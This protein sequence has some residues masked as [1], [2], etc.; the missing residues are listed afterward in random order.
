MTTRNPSN[1][2]ISRR[3]GEYNETMRF[4]E[5]KELIVRI[6]IS[7][8]VDLVFLLIIFFSVSTTFIETS[9]LKLSLPKSTGI[10]ERRSEDITVYLTEDGKIHFGGE[11]VTV[12]VLEKKLH[13][14]IASAEKK[15]VIIKADEKSR[16]GDVVT[17][18]DTARNAGAEG[19]TIATRARSTPQE[20]K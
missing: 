9:G 4:R 20:N 2:E 12:P 10:S 15:F 5:G 6:D 8:L 1:G 7:P 17:V 18:M 14:A 11:Q 13:E 16:H 3:E 19:I